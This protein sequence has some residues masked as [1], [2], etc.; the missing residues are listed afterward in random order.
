MEDDRYMRLA[1]RETELAEAELE[2]SQ[3]AWLYALSQEN[4]GLRDHFIR[5]AAR[6]RFAWSSHEERA[7]HYAG[8]SAR[9]VAPPGA[10]GG[11]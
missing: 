1:R 3:S 10:G 7:R 2:R 8:R 5:V 9:K 4:E 11:S 6:A